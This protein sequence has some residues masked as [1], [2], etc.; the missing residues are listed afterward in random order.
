MVDRLSQRL[1]A[2]SLESAKA[3][4]LWTATIHNGDLASIYHNKTY[5]SILRPSKLGLANPEEDF[6][7]QAPS[8]AQA[9]PLS[10]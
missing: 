4:Q 9:T 5:V 10:D 7:G 2:V 1:F 6:P 8:R 3:A